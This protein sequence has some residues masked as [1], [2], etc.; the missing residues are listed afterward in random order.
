[1]TMEKD[2]LTRKRFVIKKDNLRDCLEVFTFEEWEKHSL[3]VKTQLN[4]FNKEH[5]RFW[6][7]YMHDRHVVEC[8]MKQDQIDKLNKIF[9][10][11]K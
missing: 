10:K 11:D 5:V 3:N 8:W 9:G 4:F 2:E 7:A 1:M 6:M